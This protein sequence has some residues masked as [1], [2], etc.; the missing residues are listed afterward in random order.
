MASQFE[1]RKTWKK[2]W[3]FMFGRHIFTED[4]YVSYIGR[5]GA[6]RGL[7]TWKGYCPSPS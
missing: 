6:F 7:L 5:R 2:V 3:G 4:E 1:F